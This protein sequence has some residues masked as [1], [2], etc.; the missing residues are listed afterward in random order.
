MI[1]RELDRPYV[2]AEIG[3]N[4]NGDMCLAKQL[5][6]AAKL[7]GA[8]CVK[9]Q[10]W[11]KD[12]IFAKIKYEENFFLNDDYRDRE[13]YTLREIVD[14]FSVTQQELVSLKAISDGLQID[15]A[16]TPFCASEAEFIVEQLNVPFIK[17]ASMDLNNYPFL[18]FAARLGKPILLSTGLSTLSEIDRA[19][20]TIETAGNSDLS[21]MH[22]IAEY[23]PE[24]SATNLNNIATLA[25]CYPDYAIGFSDHSIGTCIPLASVALGA[26]IIEKHF[27]LDKDMFGW[28]HRISAIPNELS[29][30]CE[31]AKR[32][33]AAMGDFRIVSPE[34]DIRKSEFRRS[35]VTTQPIKKGHVFTTN[36]LAFKRP[37]TGLKPEFFEMIVGRSAKRD[38][39]QD[40]L[41]KPDDF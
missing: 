2:I 18:D 1:F 39:D 14:K 33:T 31:G 23:P 28:D 36:D 13:D 6:E 4:H 15:F 25:R 27:T 22:C 11:T 40:E 29:M 16:C 38:I 24:D 37:G 26:K 12:S 5:I 19:V 8:D 41:L 21:I 20:L 3:A 7:S 30:I 17:I 10:S 32:I 34:N 9:F 35:I